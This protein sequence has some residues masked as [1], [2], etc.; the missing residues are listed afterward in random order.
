MFCSVL[1]ES[2]LVSVCFYWHLLICNVLFQCLFFSQSKA[3]SKIF[4]LDVHIH[5][6]SN[7]CIDLVC[8]SCRC[9][10]LICI[11][12]TLHRFFVF[13]YGNVLWISI[14]LYDYF[15]NNT[16]SLACEFP[17]SYGKAIKHWKRTWWWNFQFYTFATMI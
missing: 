12:H 9:H 16:Q 5:L 14:F 11:V 13:L 4:N 6:K 10:L 15:L 1:A 17:C 2:C 3:Y 7:I 8:N